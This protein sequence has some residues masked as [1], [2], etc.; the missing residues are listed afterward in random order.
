MESNI[1]EKILEFI[2]KRA[3]CQV[4]E[5][6]ALKDLGFNSLNFVELV[7]DLETEFNIEIPPEFLSIEE[8]GNVSDILNMVEKLQNE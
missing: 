7:I 8:M 5:K 1:K 6:S 3:D 2:S 4:N